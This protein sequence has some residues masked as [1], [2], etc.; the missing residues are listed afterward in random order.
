CGRDTAACIGLGAALIARADPDAVMVVTPA[1][2]V[3]EPMEEFR[4]ALRAAVVVADE[5]PHAL[6]TFGIRPTGPA[7]GYGYVHRG[8]ALAKRQGVPVYRV[9]AFREKPAPE[10]AEQY[11][12]S[13]EYYWNSGIFVWRAATILRELRAN[14][15]AL[16]D[17]LGR[18]G[19]A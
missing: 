5:H 11:V 6:L 16:T 8:E 2:H 12:A 4:R 10:L 17:A 9:Q 19:G 13:G 15:P 1:D 3:I 18:T 7:T 14:N